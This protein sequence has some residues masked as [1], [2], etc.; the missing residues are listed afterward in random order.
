MATV[1][2]AVPRN[3][4]ATMTTAD[5]VRE[6]FDVTLTARLGILVVADD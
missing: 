4:F 1:A 5:F 3:Y 2:G 6:R